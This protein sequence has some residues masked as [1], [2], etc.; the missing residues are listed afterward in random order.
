MDNRIYKLKKSYEFKKSSQAN[1]FLEIAGIYGKGRIFGNVVIYEASL[2]F[3]IWR[4]LQ[5]L[6]KIV[7]ENTITDIDIYKITTEAG[8]KAFRKTSY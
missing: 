1:A 3:I 2:E 4:K 7:S 8:F 5:N 6:A